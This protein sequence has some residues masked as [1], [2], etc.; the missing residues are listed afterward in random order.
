MDQNRVNAPLTALL[1][2]LCNSNLPQCDSE[3]SLPLTSSAETTWAA[4]IHPAVDGR[5]YPTQDPARERS[6]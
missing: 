4:S 1:V 2:P 3:K 6:S 5:P